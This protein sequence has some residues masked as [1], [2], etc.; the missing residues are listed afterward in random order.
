MK[1]GKIVFEKNG[2]IDMCGRLLLEEPRVKFMVSGI[3]PSKANTYKRGRWGGIYVD[4][5]VRKYQNDFDWQTKRVPKGEFDKK[6]DLK[7]AYKFYVSNM[8]QDAD[9]IEKTVNDCMQKVGII[10]NDK[11]IIKHTT[12]KIADKEN[13]RIEVEIYK[14]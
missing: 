1:V 10:P 11:K 8:G 9:N 13:P 14:L 4:A 6:D 12:E 3:V 5:E 7:V 2:P